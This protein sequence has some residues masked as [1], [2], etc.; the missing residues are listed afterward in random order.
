MKIFQLA[1]GVFV[2][3]YTLSGCSSTPRMPDT[4]TEEQKERERAAWACY[5][6]MSLAGTKSGSSAEASARANKCFQ[7]PD[8][9]QKYQEQEEQRRNAPSYNCQRN[10]NGS[11][12]C[13]P[14]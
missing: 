1:F 2:T 11:F 4:R 3:I 7:D 10:Y 5:S 13:T 8:A 6:A 12:N 9:Y 14:Y